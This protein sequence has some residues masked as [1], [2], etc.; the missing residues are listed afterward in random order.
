MLP[1][2]GRTTPLFESDVERHEA[3]LREVISG[4]R[5]LVIGGAGSIGQAVVK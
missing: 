4:A 3:E 5:C 2:I 1:L